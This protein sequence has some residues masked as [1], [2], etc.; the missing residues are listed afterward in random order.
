MGFLSK[1]IIMNLKIRR[2]R[3]VW[4]F[5]GLFIFLSTTLWAQNENT[6]IKK[7]FLF[8]VPSR[9]VD[10]YRIKVPDDAKK[11]TAVVSGQTQMVT[12]EIDGPTDVVLCHN[13]T[14]SNLSDWKKPLRC[15]AN[16][17]NNNRQSPGNWMVKVKGAVHESKASKIKV[18][19]GTLTVFIELKKENSSDTEELYPVR[20]PFEKKFSFTIPSR[21]KKAYQINVPAGAKKVKA[22]I[23]NQTQMVNLNIEGPTHIVLCQSSTW[24]HLSTWQKPLSCSVSVVNNN[25]QHSGTWIVI[26]EGAIHVSK[27]DKIKTVSG[28]LTVYV[29]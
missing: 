11:V 27:M 13:S 1:T 17:V 18:V 14:W 28:V 10:V 8:T 23:T 21:G 2:E 20:L 24:S 26:V 9:G 12:L 29:Q 7:I 5:I 22:V 19:S 3:K 25:R 16:V 6:V 15:S 4:L